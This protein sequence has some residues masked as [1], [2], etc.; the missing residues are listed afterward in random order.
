MLTLVLFR[1]L[2][3]GLLERA[4][5]TGVASGGFQRRIDGF[6]G[7]RPMIPQVHQRREQIV[8]KHRNVCGDA[9]HSRDCCFGQSIFELEND[10]LGCLLADAGNRRQARDVLELDRTNQLLR[11]DARKYGERDLRPE[12]GGGVESSGVRAPGQE[13]GIS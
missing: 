7:E 2:S 8:S 13:N 6:F 10:A 3:Q 1:E 11:L 12:G 9:R 5:E 4:L